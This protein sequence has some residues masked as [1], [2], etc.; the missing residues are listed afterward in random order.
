MMQ[1]RPRT[2]LRTRNIHADPDVVDSLMHPQAVMIRELLTRS[3]VEASDRA[4]VIDDDENILQA[5][6]AGIAIRSVFHSGDA[7]VS[8]ALRRQLPAH[9]SVYEVAKRTCKKLFRNHKISR[10]FAIAEAPPNPTL[11]SLASI[12]RDI[13]VLDQVNIAGNIGAI[14]RTSLAMGVGA[15]VLL[16]AD[17]VNLHDRRL[18]RASRGYR[19]AIPVV[20]ATTAELIRLCQR[21]G[22]PL[23]VAIPRSATPVDEIQS[24]SQ[25]LAI[26]FGGEK[27][28]CSQALIDAASL[29]FTIPV[30]PAVESLNVSTAAAMTLYCRFGFNHDVSSS[31]A[32]HEGGMG[33]ALADLD[34]GGTNRDAR[35]R[36]GR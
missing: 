1:Y 29:A 2:P 30:N 9:A 25:R 19:F 36:P 34:H 18:I 3:D 5:L 7:T 20:S 8:S 23:A 10:V 32:A 31:G 24:L 11:E 17:R 28:G 33:L 27:S 4:I 21:S 6:G 12:P 22:R 15:V 35:L 16:N 26:V 13:V 14:I